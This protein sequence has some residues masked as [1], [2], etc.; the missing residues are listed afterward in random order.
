MTVGPAP[1][2]LLLA[3]AAESDD[4]A[5]SPDDAAPDTNLVETELAAACAEVGAE[6]LFAGAVV[7]EED[8]C[9]ISAVPLD[10]TIDE[11]IAQL[12]IVGQDQA[13][14]EQCFGESDGETYDRI[15]HRYEV[16]V[17]SWTQKTAVFDEYGYM[18]WESE[19]THAM[20]CAGDEDSACD[21]CCPTYCCSGV[22]TSGVGSGRP[23]VLTGCFRTGE[24]G[25]D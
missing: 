6:I 13:Y 14:R 9:Q 21:T 23:H 12:G 4:D 15:V 25:A 16:V 19:A 24:W 3:C 22:P 11:F 17:D 2:L 5:A 20:T 1:V 18:E 10:K 7:I 8:S